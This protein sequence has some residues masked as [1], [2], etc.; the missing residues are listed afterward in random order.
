MRTHV[1]V[2]CLLAHCTWK[3]FPQLFMHTFFIDNFQ[4]GDKI[5]TLFLQCERIILLFPNYSTVVFWE[6]HI[7]VETKHFIFE[8][9]LFLRYR[10]IAN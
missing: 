5:R 4:A 8:T 10:G 7:C 3:T 2:V 9:V 1:C 6:S